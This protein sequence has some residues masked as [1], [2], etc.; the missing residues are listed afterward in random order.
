[1]TKD[2]Q[3][4]AWLARQLDNCIADAEALAAA[5]LDSKGMRALIADLRDARACLKGEQHDRT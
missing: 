3:R 2:E 1:M 4:D 5:T